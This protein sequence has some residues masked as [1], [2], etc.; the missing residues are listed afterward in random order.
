MGRKKWRELL[1][2]LPVHEPPEAVWTRIEAGLDD[3]GNAAR[4]IALSFLDGLRTGVFTAVPFAPD[5][6]CRTPLGRM[7]QREFADAARNLAR[8]LRSVEL[9]GIMAG[10]D[11]ACLRY[12]LHF[13]DGRPDFPAVDWLT[14]EAGRLREVNAYFD[15]SGLFNQMSA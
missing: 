13:R 14:L 7:N 1:D 6:S 3:H 8:L 9:E 12:T 4:G 10:A 15:A 11:R 2:R 5:F